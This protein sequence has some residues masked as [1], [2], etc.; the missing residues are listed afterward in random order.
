MRIS[1]RGVLA[2]GAGLALVG[3]G[4]P[5]NSKVDPQTFDHATRVTFAPEALTLD[6]ALFPQT[7]AAG[8]MKTDSVLLWTR[9]AGAA[10]ITL[11]VWR[12][13]SATE[14]ALVTE[15]KLAVPEGG[16]VKVAVDG[17]APATWYRYAFFDVGLQQRSQL[18]KV[19]TAF[20]AD[21]R[22]TLTVGATSCASWRFKPYGP[23]VAM[24][25][26]PLDLWLHTGDVSYNDG[27]GSLDEFRTKWKEQLADPGYRALM[28]ST[29]GY[30]MWD[31]HDLVNNFDPE[32][33]GPTH[34]LMVAGKAAWFETLPV[35]RGPDDRMW[36]SYRWGK[37]AE[38]FLLDSRMERKPSTRE[39]AQAQYL[40]REQMDWLKAGVKNSPCHFKV[41]I[42]SVPISLMPAPLWGAQAERWQG[43]LAAREELLGFLDTEDIRNVW[44]VSGDFH[45]GLV[46]RVE[47]EGKRRRLI[48]IAAGPAGHVNPLAL[49]LEPGQDPANKKLAFPPDQFLFAGSGFLTTTLTF[50]PKADTVRVVFADPKKAE[51]TI[52]DQTLTFGMG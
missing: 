38:F 23:L 33:M 47:R 46:M 16:N 2:G 35:E 48:E 25:A 18:G 37:T 43:Y 12:D 9:A 28:P 32:V 42:N 36:T 44:F 8:A 4:P 50:D 15:K 52:Y 7:V 11:R 6:Q 14:V 41:L 49:V 40:S 10:E 24:G 19:R 39:T 27:A 3:C 13:V 51:P 22:E 34:P 26:Q 1:R 21:W 29:G 30:L 17:L 20:P 45:L 5:G 31:D